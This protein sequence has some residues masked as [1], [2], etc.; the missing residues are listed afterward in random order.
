VQIGPALPRRR[1]HLAG[2]SAGAPRRGARFYLVIAGHAHFAVIS[3][4]GETGEAAA[5]HRHGHQ[6][7]TGVRWFSLRRLLY[8]AA[9]RAPG[10]V[11]SG[12]RIMLLTCG[13]AMGIRTPDLLHAIQRHYV[14][15]RPSVQVTVSGRPHQSSGI[16]AGCCT[17]VLY[18][19]EPPPVQTERA[20]KCDRL[21]LMVAEC[22]A[23]VDLR[24]VVSGCARRSGA[25]VV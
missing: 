11:G 8:F 23:G 9:V 18:G 10:T 1:G 21:P 3:G 13:G 6:I 25:S 19:S 16:Q 7:R 14:H 4:S 17:F 24:P 15:P 2:T 22:Q 20:Q 5:R 12:F